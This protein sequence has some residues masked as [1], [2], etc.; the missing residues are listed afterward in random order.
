MGINVSCINVEQ[1]TINPQ[2]TEDCRSLENYSFKYNQQ[3]ATL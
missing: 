3:D 1:N 2:S